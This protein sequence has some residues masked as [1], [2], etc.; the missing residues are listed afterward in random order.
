MEV[1]TTS[2]LS[3]PV[4]LSDQGA[5]KKDGWMMMKVPVPDD[6]GESIDIGQSE[7]MVINNNENATLKTEDYWNRGLPIS[8][9]PKHHSRICKIPNKGS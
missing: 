4:E 8:L 2:A 7:S 5:L 3:I 1:N 6:L 9:K